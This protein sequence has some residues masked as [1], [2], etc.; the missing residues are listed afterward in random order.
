[1]TSRLKHK[2]ELDNVNLKSAY[3]NESFVQI[4]TPLPALAET[5]KD[6]LEYVPVWQQEARDEKG[7]RRFHGA[8]TG[9]FSAGY[10]NTVGS[11]EGWAPSSF[12]SSRSNRAT[13]TQRPEDFMDEEDLQAMNDDRRLENTDTFKG[14]DGFRGTQDELAE[15][16]W[17]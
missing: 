10:F 12:K 2:L 6:K 16:G 9:G 13:T 15:R 4:G 1:M 3:L 17:A 5:R 8:F 11:K 14:G 7:R